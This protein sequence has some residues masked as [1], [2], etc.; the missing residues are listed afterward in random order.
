MCLLTLQLN[1]WFIVQC[2]CLSVWIVH[3]F[4]FTLFCEKQSKQ[5]EKL[6]FS[7]VVSIYHP[8]V[9][10][11]PCLNPWYLGRFIVAPIHKFESVWYREWT[12]VVHSSIKYGTIM[13]VATWEC[14]ELHSFLKYI[15]I[16][17][18]NLENKIWELYPPF[19]IHSVGAHSQWRC[20]A[21]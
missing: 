10:V 11:S 21:N 13:F 3:Y 18:K 7:M 19:H 20:L 5:L 6:E 16:F 8:G 15:F 9:F 2:I 4:L 12:S 1:S 14:C 17:D